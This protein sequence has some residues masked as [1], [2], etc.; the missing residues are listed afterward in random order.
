MNFKFLSRTSSLHDYYFYVPKLCLGALGFWPLDTSEPNA[1]NVWAWMNL[2]ILTIGVFTEIHAGC[3]ALRTDLELALDTLCPA[4]TSAV[5]LLKMAL[6]YYYRK[7]LAWVLKRM[8]GFMYT[9][10]GE[11]LVLCQV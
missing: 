3:S 7:D 5:T 2:I 4:G 11:L 10:D 1:S 6:I 8:R 9:R